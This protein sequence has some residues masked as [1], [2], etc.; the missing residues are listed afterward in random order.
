MATKWIEVSLTLEPEL[1]EPVAELLSRHVPGG[2]SLESATVDNGDGEGKATGPV[3]VRAY[4]ASDKELPERRRRIEEGLWFLSRIRPLPLAQ[5]RDVEDADWAERWK[6]RY[7]P[8]HVGRSLVIVPAWL[9][10]PEGPLRPIFLDPG[11]AFGTGAHPSTR[12]S[13]AALEDH[14]R[15]GGSVADLGCGS[16]VLSIAAA[17]LGAGRV[18]ALDIDPEAVRAAR[19]NAARNGLGGAVEIHQGSLE[20]LLEHPPFD[21]LLANILAPVLVD[22]LGQG[23]AEALAPAGVAVLAGILE[24]QVEGLVRAAGG[25][26]LVLVETRGEDDWRALVL[27]AAPPPTRGG[28][29]AIR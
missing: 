24:A 7:R 20:T 28:G 4:L 5:F 17:R 19:E 2:V 15:P 23:L 6:E 29:A 25:Q 11:M 1:A 3:T 22:L 9:P 14:L 16:G 21:L 13:L 18:L 12:L 10:A 8:I 27:K 26:G